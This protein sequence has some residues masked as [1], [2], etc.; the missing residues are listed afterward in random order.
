MAGP[1]FS[2]N[3]NFS[4]EL[5]FDDMEE[6]KAHPM[7]STVLVSLDQLLQG[8]LGK[9]KE[10]ILNWSP[11]FS[12]VDQAGLQQHMAENEYCQEKKKKLDMFQFVGEMLQDFNPDCKLYLKG[13]IFDLASIEYNIEGAGYGEL[14]NLVYKAITLGFQQ[15]LVDRI[16][17]DYKTKLAEADKP[18]EEPMGEPMGM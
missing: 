18:M 4:L 8:I 3:S 1:A 10:T 5:T 12:S 7:A 11:D 2:L 16:V 17:D 15:D 9:D 14:V 13:N 6:I